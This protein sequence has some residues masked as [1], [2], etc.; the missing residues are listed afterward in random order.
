MKYL[1]DDCSEL[2]SRYWLTEDKSVSIIHKKQHTQEYSQCEQCN[3]TL[4]YRKSLLRHVSEQYEAHIF[5]CPYCH[6]H[7]NRKYQ[8]NEHK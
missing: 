5:S 1:C 4:K 3:K 8:L 6:Y 2:F 7:K